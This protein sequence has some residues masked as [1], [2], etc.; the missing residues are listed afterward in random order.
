MKIDPNQLKVRKAWGQNAAQWLWEKY[1]IT[2]FGDGGLEP[3]R[4]RKE[5]V[6]GS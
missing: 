3:S 2:C 4:L 5:P 1:K 6:V